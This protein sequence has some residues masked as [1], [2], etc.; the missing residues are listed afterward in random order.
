[1]RTTKRIISA[2]LVISLFAIALSSCGL[3]GDPAELVAEADAA[4]DEKAYT[5]R[6]V[7]QYDST[8]AEMQEAI[9]A[10]TNPVMLTEVNGDSFRI[11]ML[12]EKDGREN[13]VIYT[14]VDGVLYT[15]LD[16][17]GT[18]TKTSEAVTDLDKNELRAQLG[19]GASLSVDD[20]ENAKAITTNGESLITCTDIKDEPLDALVESL[21]SQMPEDTVVAIKDV[22]LAITISDGVY[23]Y[24]LLTCSYV[25]T[26]SDAV[27]TLNMTY[28][29]EFTYGDVDEIIAPTF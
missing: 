1:M 5:V 8:D 15:E 7:V 12:F 25:I 13:G 19:A 21:A 24:L 16:E 10:F 11:S 2:L 18:T 17:L 23:T 6:T 9:A 4:L 27:Y 14:Y 3:F 28:A 20:F 22:G 26:T 29:S